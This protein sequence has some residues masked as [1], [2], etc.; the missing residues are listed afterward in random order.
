MSGGFM[1]RAI[2][3][4]VFLFLMRVGIGK[5]T[6]IHVPADQNRDTAG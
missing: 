6:V 4:F 2:M 3:F 1:K 5:A